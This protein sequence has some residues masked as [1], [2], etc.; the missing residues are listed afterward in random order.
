[1]RRLFAFFLSVGLLVVP[2]AFAH[3]QT[4]AYAEVS[5]INVQSFPQISAL[6]DVYDANGVFVSGLQPADLT[7]Y[8]DGQQ[9]KVASITESAPPAQIV[10]AIN[11]GPP[12]AV[13]VLA[14]VA[15]QFSSLAQREAEGQNSLSSWPE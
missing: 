13:P 3:A 4:A 14:T 15:P 11:P 1:M 7:V 6:V 12:L 5:A 2:G 10:V 8:E 9:H